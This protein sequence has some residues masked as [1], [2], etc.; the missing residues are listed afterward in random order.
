MSLNI[1]GVRMA[2]VA[3]RSSAQEHK[4]LI[5]KVVEDSYGLMD[6]GCW[7][8]ESRQTAVQTVFLKDILQQLKSLNSNIAAIAQNT[9]HK[10]SG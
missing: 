5:D 7:D 10:F 4:E 8:T 3:F 1:A 6:R 9:G 2:P